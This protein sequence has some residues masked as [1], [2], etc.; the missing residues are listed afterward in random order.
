[1]A[2]SISDS[3]ESFDRRI[4]EPMFPVRSSGDIRYRK[5][6]ARDKNDDAIS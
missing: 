6:F 5:T 4:E 1:M 3:F 2:N